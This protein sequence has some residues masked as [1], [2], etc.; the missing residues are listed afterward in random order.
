MF[1]FATN[2]QTWYIVS[3]KIFLRKGT[4]MKELDLTQ[5]N[6]YKTMIKFA[7]PFLLA[8]LLQAC[9]GAADLLIV[10]AVR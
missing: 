4:N 1:S 10:G 3:G 9:Y 8:T 2:W 7:V 6:I 5:G